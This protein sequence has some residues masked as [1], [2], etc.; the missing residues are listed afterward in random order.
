[1]SIVSLVMCPCG[2]TVSK[3]IDLIFSWPEL[4]L[5]CTLTNPPATKGLSL[6]GSQRKDCSNLTTWKSLKNP[7]GMEGMEW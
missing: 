7:L 1:V 5:V 4:S 6:L 2:L 3:L